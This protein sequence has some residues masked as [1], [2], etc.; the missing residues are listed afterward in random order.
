MSKE[1]KQ[2]AD[3]ISFRLLATKKHPEYNWLL[4]R[5][6]SFVQSHNSK[7]SKDNKPYSSWDGSLNDCGDANDY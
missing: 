7:Q 1:I 3:D 4:Q 2:L 6:N 5:L